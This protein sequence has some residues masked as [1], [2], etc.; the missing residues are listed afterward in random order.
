MRGK[1][2]KYEQWE[3]KYLLVNMRQ[4]RNR[5]ATGTQAGSNRLRHFRLDTP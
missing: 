1:K 3:W 4:I 5:E 2:N